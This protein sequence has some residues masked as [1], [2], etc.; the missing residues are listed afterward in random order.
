[1]KPRRPLGGFRPP[2]PGFLEGS[3]IKEPLYHCSDKRGVD[4]LRPDLGKEFG[5]Y[6]TPRSKYARCYGSRLYEVLVN[7]KRPLVVSDKSEITPRDL[8][9]ADVRSLKARGYDGIV[10]RSGDQ[11]PFE[12]V[13]FDSEQVHIVDER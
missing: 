7:I 5:I 2:P 9:R 4:R 11:R 10:V 1:M 6:L 8:S 3:K 12:V 13:A